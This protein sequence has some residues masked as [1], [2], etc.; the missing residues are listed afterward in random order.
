V[1]E[2][3]V[4]KVGEGLCII[5]VDEEAANPSDIPTSESSNAKTNESSSLARQEHEPGASISVPDTP[6]DTY[7]VAR[8]PHPLD[9]NTPSASES[10]ASTSRPG[11][12]SGSVPT[13][14]ATDVV[15]LPS[16]RHF[17]R[18]SGVDIALLA[19]GSG[20]DGRVER[21][22]VERYLAGGKS[23]TAGE[24]QP[25]VVSPSSPA[26]DDIIVE[27]GRTR[28]GMWKAME[29]ARTSTYLSLALRCL[30]V[31]SVGRSSTESG[32]TSLWVSEPSPSYLLACT[33]DTHVVIRP[34]SI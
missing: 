31:R 30:I 4:A 14:K 5:E 6:S 15:A 27:L 3:Q 12:P 17:A 20:R 11:T 29:K 25:S 13:T 21:V 8:R 2:G 19:P 22:D 16:V 9:P 1:Q 18:E 34:L 26:E 33:T 10:S 32:D 24:Q 23:A 7:T 28:H